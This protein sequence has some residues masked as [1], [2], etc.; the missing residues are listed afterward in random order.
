[1]REC[2]E[3]TVVVESRS[4]LPWLGRQWTGAS[5]ELN[6]RGGGNE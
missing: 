3:E 6:V 1:M 4:R 5:G 2:W